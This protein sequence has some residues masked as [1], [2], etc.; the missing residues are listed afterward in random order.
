[1]LDFFLGFFVSLCNGV[2][3]EG[4]VLFIFQTLS[5]KKQCSLLILR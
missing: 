1:M 3:A 5:V 4:F 2:L